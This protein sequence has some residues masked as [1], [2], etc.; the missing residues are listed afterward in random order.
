MKKRTVYIL[1]IALVGLGFT[2]AC[3]DK[4]FYD[5]ETPVVPVKEPYTLK[6]AVKMSAE[7]LARLDKIEG[8]LTGVLMSKSDKKTRALESGEVNF[9]FTKGTD[10]ISADVQVNGVDRA[11]KQILTMTL[12]HTNG[13]VSSQVTDITE[14]LAGLN[15]MP[16]DTIISPLVTEGNTEPEI[17]LPGGVDDALG[18]GSLGDWN[19]PTD[20]DGDAESEI[21]NTND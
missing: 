19:T 17:V 21:N 14:K 15:N 20:V 13:N 12:K 11:A 2:T 1:L 7:D 3:N 5:Y 8:N 4:E 18:G 16:T 6:L 9:E 10:G